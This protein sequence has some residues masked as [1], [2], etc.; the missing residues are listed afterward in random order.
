MKINIKNDWKQ[1]LK[2]EFQKEYFKDLQN[3][4][5]SEKAV[6]KNIF[7][8]EQDIFNAFNY[9]SYENTK[10]VIIG[11][12]PYH[13]QNQAHGISFSVKEG[14]KIPPSLK[15]MYKELKSDLDKFDIPEHGYL[16]NWATQGVLM[17][18]S[19]LTVEE[20]IPA[21]HRKKGWEEFTSAA[22]KYLNDTRSD[23]VFILWGND[24]KKKGLN[25]D[26]EKHYVL[27]AAHPSPFSV[28]KFYGCRHFSKTNKFLETKNIEPIDWNSL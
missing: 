6:G 4:I 25:I 9:T 24:A 28:K 15:N 2:N 11:Q 22:I 7:P 18:N 27:E 19:V 16:K 13:G 3:Y 17:L 12:D 26:R 21:S 8:P 1:I 10:V 5:K 23:L 14:N 20:S